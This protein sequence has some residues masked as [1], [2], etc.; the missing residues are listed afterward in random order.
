M[1]LTDADVHG[2]GGGIRVAAR[3]SQTSG[4]TPSTNRSTTG[5]EMRP[6]ISTPS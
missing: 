1:S 6:T 2:P 5:F 3:R 4:T